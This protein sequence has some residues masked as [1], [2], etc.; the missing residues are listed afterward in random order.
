[1]KAIPP[2]LS[3]EMEAEA[4]LSF[5]RPERPRPAVHDVE[6][7]PLDAPLGELMKSPGAAQVLRRYLGEMMDSPMLPAMAG[8]AFRRGWRTR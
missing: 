5:S 8:K 2:G 7:G 3:E 6:P 1:M 4:D